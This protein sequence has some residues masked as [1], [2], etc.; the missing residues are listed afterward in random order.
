MIVGRV[1]VQLMRKIFFILSVLTGS[2]GAFGLASDGQ[3]APFCVEARG[4]S[5]QCIYHDPDQCRRRAGEMDGLCVANPDEVSFPSGAGGYCLVI[6]GGGV[7]CLYPDSSS[8]EREAP[9]YK[10]A[11]VRNPNRRAPSEPFR[12]NREVLY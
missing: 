8:C 11:C 5:K 9:R 3:A 6:A 2:L 12:Y 10:G 4:I 1:C 7:Q